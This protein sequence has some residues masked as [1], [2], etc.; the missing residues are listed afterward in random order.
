[1]VYLGLTLL[2]IDLVNFA[3]V[4]AMDQSQQKR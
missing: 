1:M 3:P 4:S 2:I